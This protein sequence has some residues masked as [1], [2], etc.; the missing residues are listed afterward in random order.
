M[1][2]KKPIWVRSKTP[3]INVRIRMSSYE[4]ILRLKKTPEESL[5][6]VIDR[7]VKTN[8]KQMSKQGDDV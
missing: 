3:T 2:K 7:L 4:D 8:F 1:E 6:S 5:G